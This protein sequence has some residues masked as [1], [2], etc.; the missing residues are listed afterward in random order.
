MTASTADRTPGTVK[1][2][3][4]RPVVVETLLIT[5]DPPVISP[6]SVPASLKSAKIGL[7]VPPAF[8]NDPAIAAR[9]T[10]KSHPSKPNAKF[11]ASELT[12]KAVESC[13]CMTPLADVPPP[14][15]LSN[16]MILP[17]VK[18]PA[19]CPPSANWNTIR[20]GI[21]GGGGTTPSCFMPSRDLELA[22]LTAFPCTLRLAAGFAAAPVLKTKLKQ[23]R[24]SLLRSNE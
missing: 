11:A 13:T 2:A 22:R 19:V 14:A 5:P 3:V 6:E 10:L 15:T 8:V 7:S 9:S 18:I 20:D 23:P 24:V 21:G 4:A 12:L 17:V 1:L 16:S